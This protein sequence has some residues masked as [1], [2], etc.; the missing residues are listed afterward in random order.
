MLSSDSPN[1]I[2]QNEPSVNVTREVSVSV[3]LL[4]SGASLSKAE[5]NRRTH[6]KRRRSTTYGST[7][8]LFK[9]CNFCRKRKIKCAVKS[10][11][12]ICENCRLHDRECVFDHV[13]VNQK[14]P[15]DVSPKPKSDSFI[16]HS[17][18]LDVSP[19]ALSEASPSSLSSGS[20]VTETL[21]TLYH[22]YI[23]HYTPFLDEEIFKYD[24]D[25]F[26]ESCIY[27]AAKC[28]FDSNSLQYID[29][30]FHLNL[31]NSTIASPDF[32]WNEVSLACFFLVP[33]RVPI[34]NSII[35]KSLLSFN[36][37]SSSTEKDQLSIN[38]I[39]GAMITDAYYSMFNGSKLLITDPLVPFKTLTY[40]STLNPT[41]FVY[42]FLFIG[43]YIYTMM[44]LVNDEK[45]SFTERKLRFLQL[46]FDILLWPAKLPGEL[47]IVKD[48][49]GGST[50]AFIL[51]LLHN[52]LLCCYY[53]YALKRKDTIGRM[54]AMSPV[55]GL[56]HFI[57]GLAQSTFNVAKQLDGIWT[58]LSD[59]V[60]K[61]AKC[62]ID[63]N[64][65]ME[66]DQF[67]VP[68]SLF[69]K[70]QNVHDLVWQDEVHG[71]ATTILKGFT[72]YDDDVDG[73]V[74]FWVFRDIRSLALQSQIVDKS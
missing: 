31:I 30:S 55:P 72:Y 28:N 1:N 52:T 33:L 70:F 60:V 57:S 40:L 22:N 29:S 68:L 3:P 67:K 34:G 74:V 35:Y 14:L 4:E 17:P 54:I 46:E 71:S 56:Y 20:N 26:C 6:S 63:L 51:H 61:T 13:I 50:E 39:L 37:I 9:A 73:A 18:F 69:I 36:Q 7:F 25:K 45:L 41:L 15:K 53:T 2:I 62:L 23:E 12:N 49:L 10:N 16:L 48:K 19:Q 66:F 8:K 64:D 38:L 32:E 43:Y 58:L 59:C 47:L 65:I 11:T 21:E 24:L 42:H 5:T 27:I 44:W